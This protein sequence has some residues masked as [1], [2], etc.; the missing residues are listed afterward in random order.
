MPCLEPWPRQQLRL[1][2]LTCSH[3]CTSLQVSAVKDNGRAAEGFAAEPQ[4]FVRTAC[5]EQFSLAPGCDSKPAV[6]CP[7]RAFWKGDKC[8]DT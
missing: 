6:R 2:Q 1:V 4:T 7:R 8:K 5:R 3:P